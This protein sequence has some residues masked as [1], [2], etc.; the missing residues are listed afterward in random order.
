MCDIVED[1]NEEK[2]LIGKIRGSRQGRRNVET[3]SRF[4]DEWGF[5]FWAL[6][7]MHGV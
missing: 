5:C 6:S 1:L 2:T 4:T 3:I 7:G